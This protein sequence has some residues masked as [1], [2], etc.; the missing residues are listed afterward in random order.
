MPCLSTKGA[1]VRSDIF[2]RRLFCRTKPSAALG[3][4]A[5]LAAPA[6]P[7]ATE[8]LWPKSAPN[9]PPA[10]LPP[11]CFTGAAP[12]KPPVAALRDGRLGR[13]EYRPKSTSSSLMPALAWPASAGWTF[14]TVTSL[15]RELEAG[16]AASAQSRVAAPSSDM[17]DELPMEVTPVTLCADAL[18]EAAAGAMA[19]ACTRIDAVSRLCALASSV[20]SSRSSA[21]TRSSRA[22]RA[23]TCRMCASSAS[24]LSKDSSRTRTSLLLSISDWRAEANAS[25][26][27]CTLS[28][29]RTERSFRRSSFTSASS[30]LAG[31]MGNFRSC[32]CTSLST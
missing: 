3:A 18:T 14:G 2:I 16:V 6:A 1:Y 21:A 20:K 32:L 4:A 27:C 23:S 30:S 22:S 24:T 11:A 25:C 31:A 9:F 28:M 10:P 15:R 8:R 5:A 29:S 26:N 12:S 17:L 13:P 19:E 7:T